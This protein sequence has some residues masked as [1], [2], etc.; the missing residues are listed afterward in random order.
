MLPFALGLAIL[1]AP[2]FFFVLT[3]SLGTSFVCFHGMRL[4]NYVFVKLFDPVNYDLL[5]QNSGDSFYDSLG[6]PFNFDSESVRTTGR[7]DY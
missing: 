2:W 1:L 6:P 7:E 5:K 4:F 3:F